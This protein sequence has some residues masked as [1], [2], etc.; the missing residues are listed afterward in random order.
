MKTARLYA[1]VACTGMLM[2]ANMLYADPPPTAVGEMVSG[3]KSETG[4]IDLATFHAV[5]INKAYDFLVDVREPAEF[6][7]GHIPGAINIPRG[8][9]E[10]RIWGTVGTPENTPTDQRIYLYCK[11]GGRCALAAESL[12]RLGFTRAIPVDM[13]LEQWQQAGYPLTEPDSIQ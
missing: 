6:A 2:P 3:A 11:T 10:F 12:Q 4:A 7:S 5:Y 13:K 1:V 8:V 9:I